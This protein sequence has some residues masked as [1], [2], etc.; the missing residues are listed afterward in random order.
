[1]RLIAIAL[2]LITHIVGWV[3]AD[4]DERRQM[5]RGTKA[6][7]KAIAKAEQLER[8]ASLKVY[9][10]DR[11]HLMAKAEE[12]KGDKKSAALTRESEQQH[13]NGAANCLRD[14]LKIRHDANLD[15]SLTWPA[16]LKD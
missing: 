9:D 10:A 16:W 3:F 7:R 11:L 8:A 14:A 15:T 1:M 12:R 13:R 6:H 2:G 4:A 5:R